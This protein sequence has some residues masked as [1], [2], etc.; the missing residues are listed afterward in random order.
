MAGTSSVGG[1]ISGLDTATIIEQLIAVSKKRTDVVARNQTAVDNKLTAYQ[2]LNTQL[3]SFKAKADILRDVDTFKVFKNVTT[4]N[5]A[6]FDPIDLLSVSTTTDAAPGTHTI[7]FTPSSQLA[8]ARKLSS[9]SYSS[10]STALGITGEFVINGKA[11]SV[12][13]TDSLNDIASSISNANSGTDA[14]GVTATILTITSTDIRLVLT[15]DNTGKDKFN[16]LDAS[17][18]GSQDILQG[19]STGL[20]FTTAEANE[21]IKNATSDGAESDALSNSNTAVGSLLGLTN[22]QSGTVTI[23]DYTRTIDLSTDS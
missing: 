21:T 17:A 18:K 5:S 13:T 23:G 15:S 2:S 16:I 1:L 20:G 9:Q 8:Q 6:T 3:L 12:V 14:T 19:G 22:A 7:K 10:A 4:T 11:I